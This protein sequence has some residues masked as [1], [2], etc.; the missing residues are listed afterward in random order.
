MNHNVLSRSIRDVEYLCYLSNANTTIFEHNFLDFF[1]DNFKQT[2]CSPE[3]EK[4]VQ[5]DQKINS[6]W[7]GYCIRILGRAWYFVY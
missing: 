1:D 5:I 6:G 3:T 7:Q 2:R 4:A